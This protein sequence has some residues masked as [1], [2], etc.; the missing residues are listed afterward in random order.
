MLH[1]GRVLTSVLPLLFRPFP[2]FDET[3]V[4]RCEIARKNMYIKQAGE[5]EGKRQRTGPGALAA[6]S[7]RSCL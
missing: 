7:A 6:R 2:R 1:A 3:A 4:L 5:P